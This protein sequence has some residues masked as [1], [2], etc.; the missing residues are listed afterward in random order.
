MWPEF[1]CL[2]TTRRSPPASQPESWGAGFPAGPL[3]ELALVSLKVWRSS[4]VPL[5]PSSSSS[6]S[7]T[8]CIC[9]TGSWRTVEDREGDGNIDSWWGEKND[10]VRGRLTGWQVSY[11]SKCAILV[12]SWRSPGRAAGAEWR[13]CG[14]RQG[15]RSS[16]GCWASRWGNG[17]DG[18]GRTRPPDHSEAET[19]DITCSLS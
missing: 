12:F 6:S 14:L 17:Y 1:I 8:R 18:R 4:P 9:D 16:A 11:L 2:I 7:N 5:S 13:T 15:R 3:L 19:T 10:V